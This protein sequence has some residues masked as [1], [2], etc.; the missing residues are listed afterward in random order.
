M[1]PRNRPTRKLSAIPYLSRL[2]MIAMKT[3]MPQMTTRMALSFHLC[4]C[5]S[6]QA[7]LCQM[8]CIVCAFGTAKSH[9]WLE[10][11]GHS[12]K[13]RRIGSLPGHIRFED[14]VEIQINHAL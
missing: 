14:F 5:H 11:G 13:W 7:R 8:L 1:P 10:F 2:F 4:S 6:F 3:A 12:R 9:G